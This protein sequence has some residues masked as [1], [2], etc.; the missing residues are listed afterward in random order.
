MGTLKNRAGRETTR[1]KETVETIPH[2]G[3]TEGAGGKV[4]YTRVK[5]G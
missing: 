5:Y 1:Y 2:P 3:A 4:K